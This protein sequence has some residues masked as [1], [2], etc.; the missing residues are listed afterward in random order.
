MYSPWELLP[1]HSSTLP[2][3]LQH[4]RFLGRSFPAIHI[5]YFP[6]SP[7]YHAHFDVLFG[8]GGFA[9]AWKRER[10]VAR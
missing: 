7:R 5:S 6:F 4:P 3:Q 2:S 10:R 1:P 9:L 8:V